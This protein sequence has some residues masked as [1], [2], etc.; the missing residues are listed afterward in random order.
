MSERVELRAKVEQRQKELGLALAVAEGQSHE[1]D[2][3]N[4]LK[5]E[6]RVAEDAVQGGWDKVSEVGAEQL[7][8]WLESTKSMVIPPKEHKASHH[9]AKAEA[10]PAKAEAHPAKAEAHKAKA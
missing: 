3:L 10:H 7:S 4:A 2:R 1:V 6:L 8:H 9:A 5:A